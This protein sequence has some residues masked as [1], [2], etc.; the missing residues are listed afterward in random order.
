MRRFSQWMLGWCLCLCAFVVHGQPKEQ[1]ADLLIV[2]GTESGWA[3]A[4]QAARMGVSN[5]VVVNDI[6]WLGGQ[7][8][9]EAVSAVDENR[10]IDNKVPFPRSGLFKEFCDR[11]ENFNLKKYGSKQPGNAWTAFTTFRPAEGEKVFREMLQPYIDRKQVQLISWAYPVEAL[12]SE[13]KNTLLGLTFREAWR[14][15]PAPSP[16]ARS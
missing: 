9:A 10:G 1:S 3:A 14:E 5:I 2:G 11:I 7:F 4:I 6:E 13:D 12:L 15:M 16:F 8:T